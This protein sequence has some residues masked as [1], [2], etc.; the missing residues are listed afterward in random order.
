MPS[1]K[2]RNPMMKINNNFFNNGVV[3]VVRLGLSSE[4][5]CEVR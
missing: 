3:L 5:G 1:A 2:K 4:F